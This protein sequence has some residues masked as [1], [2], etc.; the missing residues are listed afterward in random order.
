[1]HTET[2]LTDKA[3]QVKYDIH[4]G[5]KDLKGACIL[6]N[7]SPEKLL[8]FNEGFIAITNHD[9]VKDLEPVRTNFK[10]VLKGFSF[11]GI[12]VDSLERLTKGKIITSLKLQS[13]LPIHYTKDNAP[14]S[15]TS[16]SFENVY[17]PIFNSTDVDSIDRSTEKEIALVKLQM[18]EEGQKQA[19]YVQQKQK[20]LETFSAVQATISSNDMAER[21]RAIKEQERARA[22]YKNLSP[23]LDNRPALQLRLGYL[24]KRL[25]IRKR[26]SIIGYIFYLLI[27]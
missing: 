21:E 18:A 17:N 22:A 2:L 8:V 24:N 26:Q 6:I 12:S 14:Q 13:A 1:V 4:Q 27:E 3:I 16:I 15:G 23:P 7:S 25:H 19:H 20:A 5:G 11:S 10:R 9:R